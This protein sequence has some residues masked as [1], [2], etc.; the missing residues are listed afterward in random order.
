M[1]E[2]SLSEYSAEIKTLIDAEALDA[3]ISMAQHLLRQYPK[4]IHGYRLLAQAALKKGEYREAADLF[5]RVL[6]ADPEDLEARTGLALIY[7]E[8]GILDEA[9]WQMLRAFELAPGNGDVRQTLRRLFEQRDGR[10]PGRLKLNSAALARVYMR[11]GW[12][13]RAIDELRTQIDAESDRVDLRVALAESLWYAGR[14]QEAVETAHEILNELPYCLKANLILGQFYA[15]ESDIDPA[16]DRLQVAQ[17]L[18]PENQI[19]Q[20]L[21]GAASYLPHHRATV[22]PAGEAQGVFET[23]EDE[24]LPQWLRSLS[25]DEEAEQ[26]AWVELVAGDWRD[27]LRAATEE[28][29]DQWQPDWRVELRRATDRAYPLIDEAQEAG[30]ALSPPSGSEWRAALRAATDDALG[31]PEAAPPPEPSE[32]FAPPAWVSLLRDETRPTDMLRAPGAPP[33]TS[34]A[35]TAAPKPESPEVPSPAVDQ[36]Q[37]A[38]IEAEDVAGTIAAQP[39]AS[40]GEEHAAPAEAEE[41]SAE[42]AEWRVA[43]E[44][45]TNEALELQAE[46]ADVESRETVPMS[47]AEA[48]PAEAVSAPPE[49]V[50]A[51]AT[52]EATTARTVENLMDL[53]EREPEN[54]EARLQLADQLREAGQE[55]SALVLY[56]TIFEGGTLDEPLTRRL[57]AWIDGGVAGA[58]VHQLLGDVYRRH[59]QLREAVAQYRAAINKM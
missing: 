12:Y 27:Q 46:P 53:V 48:E 31:E 51:G 40:A 49:P 41:P 44:Q 8:E 1:S 2:M 5:R 35:G 24:E 37:A 18:D 42:G 17:A 25:L 22:R 3:A 57:L 58:R 20:Q 32:A 9:I 4:Y 21:F 39:E 28:A 56:E 54:L 23:A 59:G 52:G 33:E 50:A 13:E 30:P 10:A 55:R 45:A 29:L 15:Q 16:W 14:R 34:E 38:P 19:A 36:G 26:E 6:S 11:D 43:L 47:P 7:R